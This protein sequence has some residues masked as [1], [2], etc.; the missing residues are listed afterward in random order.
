MCVNI[1]CLCDL[2]IWAMYEMGWCWDVV[3]PEV[4]SSEPRVDDNCV[5]GCSALF[6][7]TSDGCRM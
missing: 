6:T 4:Y 2:F 3:I 1:C 7:L 5:E